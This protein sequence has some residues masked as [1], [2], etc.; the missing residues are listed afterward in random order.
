MRMRTLFLALAIAT[1]AFA[2]SQLHYPTPKKVEQKDTY[3]GNIVVADPYR[4]L[5]TDVRES[6]DVRQ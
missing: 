2:Q 6:D 1:S 4:W 3:A 5:E